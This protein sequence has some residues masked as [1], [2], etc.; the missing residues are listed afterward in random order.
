M[1]SNRIRQIVTRRGI[2]RVVRSSAVTFAALSGVAQL[3][4]AFF[5]PLQRQAFAILGL[6]TALSMIWGV[7]RSSPPVSVRR[8]FDRPDFAVRVEKGDIFSQ[9]S[10]VVIGFT[11]VFDTDIESAISRRSVQGQFLD[12]VFSGDVVRLDNALAESLRL[13]EPES[14]EDPERKRHGKLDRYPIGT[15]AVIREQGKN[16]YCLA[17]SK[18][19][20]SMVA[21]SSIEDLWK[22]L[23]SLWEAVHE[24]EER[25]P[26]SIPVIGGD[27]ARIDSVDHETLIKLIIIS[28]VARSRKSVVASELL[29]TVTPNNMSR[30][31]MNEVSAFLN[32]I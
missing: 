4:L 30:V 7:S 22:S 29:I 6:I 12:R 26:L 9:S 25:G 28:F 13:T 17:Y 10:G 5:P 16:F 20:P 14:Q 18:M 23:T 32:A 8:Q 3:L 31:D 1:N 27:L 19:E 21:K 2:G 24:N 11:D 15:V